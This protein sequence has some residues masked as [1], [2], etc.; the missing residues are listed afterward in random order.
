MRPLEI[1]RWAVYLEKGCKKQGAWFAPSSEL[2]QA[3]GD[4]SHRKVGK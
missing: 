2:A 1:P 4:V 3:Q